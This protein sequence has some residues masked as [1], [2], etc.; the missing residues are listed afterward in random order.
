MSRETGERNGGKGVC[1]RGE[2]GEVPNILM[3]VLV[4]GNGGLQ[5]MYAGNMGI[6]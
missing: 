5:L 3:G 2:G 4:C 1:G 6:V